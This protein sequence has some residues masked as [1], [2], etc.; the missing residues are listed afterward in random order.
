MLTNQLR[1]LMAEFG[2][3]AA[4]G[5]GRV[6]DLLAILADPEDQRIPALL[7]EALM[8]SAQV[9]RAVEQEIAAVDRLILAWGRANETC[10]HLRTIPGFGPLLASAMAAMAVEPPAFRSGRDFADSL[11]PVPRQ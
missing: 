9:L 3:V 2:V 10:R 7:A 8:A 4:A 6:D 5:R 11:G 1:G